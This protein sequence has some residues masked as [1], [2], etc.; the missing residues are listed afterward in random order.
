MNSTNKTRTGNAQMPKADETKWLTGRVAR[1][2]NPNEL[3]INLGARHGVTRNSRFWIVDDSI[4]HVL[5]PVTGEDLGGVPRYKASLI[6]SEVGERVSVAIRFNPQRALGGISALI[7]GN[8]PISRAGPPEWP[9]KINV[10]DEVVGQVPVAPATTADDP[11][12]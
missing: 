2:L 7:A 4:N 5:D 10:G 11:A 9:E 6:I 3:V 12:P 1:I 8:T